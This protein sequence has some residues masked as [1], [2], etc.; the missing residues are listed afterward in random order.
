M[1]ICRSDSGGL[2]EIKGA[3]AKANATIIRDMFMG[4]SSPKR[5]I[6]VLN[7]AAALIAA[8]KVRNFSEGIILAG[9]VIE[10]R[11][12]KKVLEHVIKLSKV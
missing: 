12:A 6:V 1:G 4:G 8:G 7:S 11:E 10:N 3:D 5:D 9:R 2:S